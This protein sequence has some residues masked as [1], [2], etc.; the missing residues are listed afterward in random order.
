VIIQ[1]QINGQYIYKINRTVR[2]TEKSQMKEEEKPG[3]SGL[4]QN[5]DNSLRP[6][7]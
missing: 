4:D 3:I 7:F 6:N 5:R 1:E 2:K